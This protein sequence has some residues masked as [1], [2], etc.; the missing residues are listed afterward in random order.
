MADPRKLKPSELLQLV[1]STPLGEVIGST[2]FYRLRQRAGLNASSDGKTMHLLKFARWLIGQ[3]PPPS[4]KPATP[5]A[6]TAGQAHRDR[7]AAA[8]RQKMASVSDLGE[9]PPIANLERREACKNDLALFCRTYNP[10]AFKIDWADYHRDAIRRIE[11]SVILGAMFAFAM[12]RGGGKSS[13]C[14][15]AMLW[16]V[17]YAHRRYPFYI[18]ATMPKGQ[19]G[20]DA[21]KIFMRFLPDYVDDFP[22]IAKPIRAL[23]G[24]PQ[25]ATSQHCCG[26][27][28][29]IEWNQDHI[30]LPTVPPPPNLKCA[31]PLAPTSG[32]VIGASGLTAEGIRGSLHTLRS[33]ELLRPD[34]VILDDPQTDESAHSEDQNTKRLELIHGAVLGMAGPGKSISA[35]MPCTVIAPDDMV[36][37]TLDRSTHPLWRGSRTAMLEGWPPENLDEWEKYF[38]IYDSCA[39]LEPPDFTEANEY[40]QANAESLNGRLRATWSERRGWEISAVQHAMNLYRRDPVVF[41]A[42]YMNDPVDPHADERPLDPAEL[43]KRRNGYTR[44]KVPLDVQHITAYIDVQGELLFW[45]VAGW[46]EGFAGHILDYGVF[47]EQKRRRFTLADAGLT[48]SKKYPGKELGGRLYAGMAG[49]AEELMPR[50][51]KRDD[52]A[53]LSI[54]R[55][56]ID[57]NWGQSTDVVYQFCRQSPHASRLTPGHGKYYG[58][59][60]RGFHEQKKQK[61]EQVGLHWRMPS[62][63]GR[64]QCRY[65][66][67]DTNFWKSFV[68]E[69][70]KTG[71][72]DRGA[73]QFFGQRGKAD[74]RLHDLLVEHLTAER[75]VKVVANDR[76]MDEWDQPDRNRD[77]HWWD[78]L[79]GAAVAANMVGVTSEE[80]RQVRTKMR[81]RK[82]VSINRT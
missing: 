57:A 23:E 42:E 62:V 43:L 55:C 54:G 64:R 65:V 49:L 82:T 52:G 48:L 15:M 8:S 5:P 66:V 40:Y 10:E 60:S 36:D 32:I 18:G 6:A 45:L 80:H 71:E 53:E 27:P 9:I 47:P 78:C 81:R 22:E 11:E 35:V 29:L 67:I 76:T 69:R 61:G 79:V 39:Q 73:I 16:A 70:L 46:C 58:A 56:V 44:G 26:E 13:L 28:T 51:F 3:V 77:N 24:R 30:V 72:G 14:R 25:R 34:F 68:A 2:A 37:K 38:E 4:A 17:S 20:L 59:K 31:G 7:M 21:V 41:M 63:K 33:G 75:C 50:R 1:N 12:P 19:A 74:E